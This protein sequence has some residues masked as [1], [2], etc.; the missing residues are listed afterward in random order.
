M[1]ECSDILHKSMRPYTRMVYDNLKDI[2]VMSWIGRN[3]IVIPFGSSQKLHIG[4]CA[5]YHCTNG[6]LCDVCHTRDNIDIPN[7]IDNLVSIL[8]DHNC[9]LL[10]QN[11]KG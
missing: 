8:N 11:I 7:N 10:G 1:N 5:I 2:F 9:Y 3:G 6:E 4:E